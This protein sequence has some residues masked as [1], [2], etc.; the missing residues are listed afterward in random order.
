[1]SGTQLVAYCRIRYGGLNDTGR[2]SN[3]RE[4]IGK[5]LEKAKSIVKSGDVGTILNVA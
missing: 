4:A 3:Q 1:M 5:M 2:T